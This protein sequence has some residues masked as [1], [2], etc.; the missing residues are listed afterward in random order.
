MNTI[1]K[2]AVIIGASIAGLAAARA[3]SPYFETVVLIER[4]EDLNTSNPR[5]AIPQGHHAHALLKSGEL[6]LENLFPNISE[7]LLDC[8]A[9]RIDFSNDV[10][11][12]HGGQ[13]KMRYESGFQIMIQSRP[14][15]EQIIRHRVMAL[16]NIKSYNGY[17][18]ESLLS[19]SEKSQV[20]GVVLRDMASRSQKIELASDL[21]IDASG[22][23]SKMPQWLEG[24]GYAAPEETRLKID[25]TYSSRLYQ[26]PEGK[27]FD[28]QLL[29]MNPEAP[30]I[31]KAGYI[32]PVENNQWLITF[33][34]YSGDATPKDNESF[35]EFAK[36][37]AQPDI[38]EYMQE[39]IPIGD[40]KVFSVPQ[41]VRRHYEKVQ[42]PEGLLVMGD[43][44]C[45][46]DPVFGQGMSA[47]AKEA[48][49]LS[50]LLAKATSLAQFGKQFHK[51]VS[52]IIEAPWML[53]SSEDFRYP[54]TVG[55]KS[56]LIP[57]LHWYS[58][59]IFVLSAT[60]KEVAE[61]FRQ[62]MHLLEGAEALFKPSVVVKVLK[63]AF[64]N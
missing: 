16:G 1:A 38:Y 29:V 26:A 21:L 18:V 33:A 32:F 31:L 9:K 48:F 64:A 35:I 17:E 4:D 13:W 12:Y 11:W 46:F 40:V 55:K 24:M 7:E 42:M 5:K 63:H 34:G 3:L 27:E 41:T 22:R 19:N 30:E 59:H 57:I 62:V 8:G 47:A 6:A 58:N 60:D 50:E 15:L 56:L 36:G 45:A 23:G 43:A 51:Q 54:K 49:A 52:D 44:F 37:L 10:R 25:L 20:T 14:L 53:A 39:L 28:W 2:Q 61:A